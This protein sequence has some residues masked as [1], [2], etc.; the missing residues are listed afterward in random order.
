MRQQALQN[1]VAFN[2]DIETL[3][4]ALKPF[5]W[6]S[7]SELVTL[8]REHI[9]KT[10]IRYL[11]NTLTEPQLEDWANT[12]EGRDDIGFELGHENMIQEVI[13]RLANPLITQPITHENVK[14]HLE[15]L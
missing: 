3:K 8:T 15:V 5:S 12:I 13:C 11:E 4:K 2:T 10:L 14:N 7:D 1:L 6:D 9:R